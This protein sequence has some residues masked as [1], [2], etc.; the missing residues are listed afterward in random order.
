MDDLNRFLTAQAP[1]Y[2]QVVRELSAGTKRSHW[3]WFIF[4]QIAGLGLSA[5]SRHFAI[6]SLDEARAYLRHPI[7]GPRLLECTDL[8]NRI[9]DRSAHQIFGTPDDTKF[10]SCMTLFARAAGPA[11]A[12]RCRVAPVFRGRTGPADTRASALERPTGVIS[13]ASFCGGS[14][15]LP[16][17]LTE[18][19]TTPLHP[20]TRK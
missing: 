14:P 19:E 1:V 3:M 6:A 4:P 16:G 13:I 7:L 9:E 15:I 2:D 12:V 20:K 8:V 10:R 17:W 5:T 11:S 18:P